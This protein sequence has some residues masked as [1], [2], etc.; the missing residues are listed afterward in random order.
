MR[1]HS[2]GRANFPA[3]SASEVAMPYRDDQQTLVARR[4]E[5]R[6]DLADATRKAEIFA[7][8]VRDKETLT[9]ELASIEARIERTPSR[10]LPLLDAVSIA[11]PCTASWDSMIGDERVRFCGSCQ[12]NV[13]NLSAM[14]SDE[15]ERLLAQHEG[16]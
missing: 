2:G 16:A 3:P 15:A 1:A 10:R 11:S 14:V 4:E 9:R 7:D 8:A 12:K 6:R 5:L 13:Y